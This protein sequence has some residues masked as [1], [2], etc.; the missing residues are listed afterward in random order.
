[1][2]LCF[3]HLAEWGLVAENTQAR[4]HTLRTRNERV[5]YDLCTIK[6]VAKLKHRRDCSA[7]AVATK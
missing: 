5:N 4:R 1:M 7:L 6:E 2:P 3:S